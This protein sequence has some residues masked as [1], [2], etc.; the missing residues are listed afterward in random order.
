MADHIE[1]AEQEKA[2]SITHLNQ[3]LQERTYRLHNLKRD[4]TK[5]SE[6]ISSHEDDM[7]KI[8]RVLQRQIDEKQDTIQRYRE[9][10]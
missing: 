3:L 1:K 4:I 6:S 8:T 5:C 2:G 10:L 7:L 9:K